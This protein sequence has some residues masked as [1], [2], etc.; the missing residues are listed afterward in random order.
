MQSAIVEDAMHQARLQPWVEMECYQL[1][2]GR[3]L[4][5][6]DSLDL[7][8]QQIVRERQETDIQKLGRTPPDFC[9]IS[10]CTTDLDFRFSEHCGEQAD[11]IFFMP[12][13]IEYD[14]Y[15]SAGGNCAYAGFSQEEFLGG[16]R[17]LNPS[18]WETPPKS[19][20]PLTS[21]GQASFLQAVDLWLET[22]REASLQGHAPAQETLRSHILNAVL[23]IIATAGDAPPPSVNERMRA[24]QIGRKARSFVYDR[25]GADELPTIVEICADLGVSERSLRYA[26]REYVGLSPV[27]YLRA[28]RLNKVR[29]LLAASDPMETTITQ[30]AMHYGFLHLGRFAV[31]YKRMFGVAP[32]ETLNT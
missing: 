8:S 21:R 4:A 12:A 15:V 10:T 28:C 27:A 6:F 14:I 19:V 1:S 9:T 22:A 16:A 29:H 11:M 25:L 30:V 5:T 23:D 18:F 7:G 13:N 20:M 3:R 17:I 24:L 26:L 32:S 2:N 31:D